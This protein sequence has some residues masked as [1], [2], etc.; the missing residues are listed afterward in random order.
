MNKRILSSILRKL[1]LLRLTD[2]IRFAFVFLSTTNARN[3]FKKRNPSINLPPDYYLYETYKLDYPSYFYKGRESAGQILSLLKNYK[4]L[5]SL[6][7]LDWGCGPGRI[8]R[9]LPSLLDPSCK[10]YGTDPNKKYVAWCQKNIPE[11]KF[12]A[13]DW[14][15]PMRN[16]DSNFFDFIYGI[17]IFTHMS[18]NMHFLW[19]EEIM[20]ILKPGGIFLFTTQGASFVEKLSKHELT[21]F[22]EGKIIEKSNTKEGHR[23]YSSFQPEAFIRSMFKNHAILE[24]IPGKRSAG[25]QDIWMIKKAGP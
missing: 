3:Q 9:H 6:A 14:A 20:R 18:G 10:I 13:N 2:K 5:E 15:P 11:I 12:S 24:H 25:Q 7:I 23:T 19:Q 16:Y 21:L 17:S 1:G 4:S 8:T 22:H